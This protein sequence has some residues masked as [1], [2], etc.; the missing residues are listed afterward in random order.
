MTHICNLKKFPVATL[1][2][3]LPLT[4]M[5]DLRNET[6]EKEKKKKGDKLKT[7]TFNIEDKQMVTRGK[8]GGGNE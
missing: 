2:L 6:N 3:R 1:K 5:W 4:H 7:Q 8:V